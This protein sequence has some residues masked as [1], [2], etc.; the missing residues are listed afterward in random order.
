[1]N[2]QPLISIVTPVMNRATMIGTAMASVT[3]QKFSDYEHIIVDGG[4]TDGTLEMV[5]GT[6]NIQIIR[7]PDRGVYDGL[8]KGVRA[9]RG[10]IIGHLNSDDVYYPGVFAAVAAQFAADPSLEIVSGGATISRCDETGARRVVRRFEAR[11]EAKFSLASGLTG[12]PLPNARFIRRS[13]YDRI[14]LYDISY[15]LAADRDLLIRAA[16]ADAKSAEIDMPAYDYLAHPGSLTMSDGATAFLPSSLEILQLTRHYMSL[17]GAPPELRALCRTLHREVAEAASVS[18]LAS[19]QWRDLVR[20]VQRG[21]APDPA[22]LLQFGGALVR[23]GVPS[24]MRR[25]RRRAA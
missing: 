11:G 13:L 15:K 17:A 12:A 18:L 20:I 9:A 19:G 22:W 21:A 2:K 1:L 24:L 25:W 23:R 6:I 14:G 4:S 10:A 8:N 3:S 7:G 16:L 5:S